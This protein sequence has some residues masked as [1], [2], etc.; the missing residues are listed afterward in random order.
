[1][2]RGSG[3]DE[4][5][6]REEGRS[7]LTD[8]EVARFAEGELS[9]EERA[10]VET[11]LAD[12]EPCRREVTEVSLFLGRDRAGRR[13][14]LGG[15]AVAATAA[16]VL[17][18]VAWPTGTSDPGGPVLRGPG[19]HDALPTITALAPVEDTPV[20]RDSLIFVWKSVDPEAYYRVTV[21]TEEGATVWRG[22]TSDTSLTVAAA[23]GLEPGGTYYWFVDALLPDGRESTTGVRSFRLRR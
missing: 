5:R 16:A 20:S 17:L 2:R 23:P 7:H 13:R 15:T 21:A 8:Q 1:M 3:E 10:S 19:A 11:H 12:C 9:A 18:V 22:E 14:W 4:R 6:D